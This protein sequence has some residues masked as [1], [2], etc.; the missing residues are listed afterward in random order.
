[1]NG[2]V[3][4]PA[5]P[6]SPQGSTVAADGW[7]PEVDVT[8]VRAKIRIGDGIVTHE[9]M[10]AA[11]EGAMLSAFRAL[12]AWR[13]KQVLAGVAELADIGDVGINGKTPA[14]VIW[15]R[16][17][18]YYTAA[19]LGDTHRDISATDQG[20]IRA[21]EERRSADDYRRMAYHAVADMLSIGE[22]VPVQRNRVELI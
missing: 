11:I 3:S 9:R 5:A 7:F 8:A 19:E 17:I 22:A 21:D 2:L 1:V 20:T 10:V 12:A 16:I 15:E 14:I 18:T 4:T 6:A 13:T